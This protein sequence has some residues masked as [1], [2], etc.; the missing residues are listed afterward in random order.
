VGRARSHKSLNRRRGRASILVSGRAHSKLKNI[1]KQRCLRWVIAAAWLLGA[2][3]ASNPSSSPLPLPDHA[4]YVFEKVGE[5]LGLGTITPVYLFQDHEGF[6]WIASMSGL[7]R[8][9][10]ARAVRFGAEQGIS[11]AVIEEIT[12]SADGRIWIVSRDGL[13]VQSGARFVPVALPPGIHSLATYQPIVVKPEGIYLA[14]DSGL[15]MLDAGAGS[16][17]MVKQQVFPGRRVDL[18]HLGSDGRVWFTL[19]N[20]IGWLD[21]AVHP[22]FLPAQKE[23]PDEPMVALLQDGKRRLWLRTSQHLL[24]LEPG[25]EQFVLD[26]PNLPPAN[27]VGVPAID[28]HGRLMIP[29]IAGLYLHYDDHWDVIDKRRGTAANATF[30]AMQD[31][32]GTY[33][34]GLGGNGIERWQGEGRWSGWTDAE[35]LPDNV[36]WAELRDYQ[37]RLWV[38][39]NDGVAMWDGDQHRFRVWKETNGVNGSMART[40]ALGADG[41]I[42]V[43]CHPGGLTRFDPHTLQPVK[44]ATGWPDITWIA[45]GPDERLWISGPHFLQMLEDSVSPFKFRDVGA[46]REIV[47]GVSNFA[48][49]AGGVVWTSGHNGLGRYDGKSW[50]LYTKKDGLLSDGVLGVAPVDGNEVWIHY[51]DA[52][53]VTRFRL[54]NQ[55]PEVEHF[56]QQDGLLASEVFMLGRDRAG[57]IWAGGAQGLTRIAQDHSMRRFRRDDGLIWDDQ[58]EGG[59]YA[60]QDGT[61]LF[62]TSGG[63]ARFDPHAETAF[64]PPAFNVVI[65]SAQLG[66][67]ERLRDENPEATHKENTLRAQFSVLSYRNPAMLRCRSRLTGLENE[68]TETPAREVRYASLAPGS[69]TLEISCETT[70]GMK[71]VPAT[72]SFTVLPAWWQTWWSRSLAMVFVAFA[73]YGILR[74]R[75]YALEK[76]RRN[77]E[78]AVAE[79]SAEL[80]RL[81][82]ELREASLTDPLTGT[83]NRRFFQVTI[84]GDTRQAI[85]SYLTD[86]TGG[87]NRDL[88]FYIV[89]ADLFKEVNDVYGHAAGDELLSEMTKRIQSAIRMSDVLVRWGGEEFLV[90]S[91]YTERSEATTLASRILH[92]VGNE[93]FQLKHA[94]MS[95]RRT[96]SIGW[97]AFPWFCAA[98]D[99]LDYE[100]VVELAD[101]ALYA[102]KQGGRNRAVGMLPRDSELVPNTGK[103][104]LE[105]VRATQVT[106]MGPEEKAAKA[107]A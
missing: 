51:A 79:R 88:I 81:N 44:V 24:R 35:G 7:L 82:Q 18:V 89:D 94:G 22:H 98:P 63:L 71:S 75:T 17:V 30:S 97:A 92:M 46:P 38:G 31:R 76:D 62:G 28:G 34:I 101:Q 40:L 65:N 41:S 23:V 60:E 77:L 78:Q 37:Q 11:R 72:F 49:A 19:G 104:S 10:G 86:K 5:D 21:H 102:A 52:P 50:S 70:S 4:R 59:F 43:L 103:L 64:R 83:R 6:I 16:T 1:R 12:E 84:E 57:R 61:I 47:D 85:R 107:G 15:W 8:Y 95:V 27:D 32:E 33:W 14:S 67:Q 99:V 13:V 29:T 73:L 100:A 26:A 42:W 54:D 69:Y 106:T 68:F 80:E 2:L 105:Q 87:R 53:G 3:H 36:V 20:R 39:T 96:C 66:G 91:R 25:T 74:F 93:P 45:S 56:S 48:M 55:K 9:D 90:V 58:S